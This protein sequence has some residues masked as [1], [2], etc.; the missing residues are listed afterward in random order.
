MPQ[1]LAWNM[2]VTGN[3][4]SVPRRPQKS[5]RLATSVCSTVERCEYTTPLG[6]P[7]VPEV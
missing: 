4:T 5:P 3:T 1:L 7:V 6:C 2:G